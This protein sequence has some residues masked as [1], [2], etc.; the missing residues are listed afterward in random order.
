MTQ[1]TQGRLT[2]A[3]NTATR[4]GEGIALELT[5]LGNAIEEVHSD[6]HGGAGGAFQSVSGD[7]SNELKQILDALNSMAQN[8][9]GANAEYGSTDEDAAR[10]IT[11][12]AQHY[13]PGAMPVADA[14]R[15]GS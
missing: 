10:E 7:L 3:A 2:D 14:L 6:F 8:V 15:G 13:E 12:V 4:V 1:V 11:N 9:L 5:R